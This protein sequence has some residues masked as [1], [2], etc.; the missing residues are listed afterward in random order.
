MARAI[1][2]K[3]EV[4]QGRNFSFIGESM[5]DT[6][7]WI[8]TYGMNT[9]HR[10]LPATLRDMANGDT[11]HVAR[12]DKLLEQVNAI[13]LTADCT[14]YVERVVAGGLAD[15]PAF[16][17]GS[18]VAMRQRRKREAAKPLTMV[19]DISTSGSVSDAGIQRRGVAILA[20]IQK[21]TQAGH[22]IT[23]H[24]AEASGIAGGAFPYNGFFITRLDTAPLDLARLCWGL[25]SPD[26]ARRIAFSAEL[27]LVPGNDGSGIGWPRLKG[28]SGIGGGWTD[29]GAQNNFPAQRQVW[30][31]I[32]GEPANSIMVVPP[33]FGGNPDHYP[34]LRDDKGAAEWVTE[35][36]AKAV[37][38][39]QE[40]N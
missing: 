9:P 30:A 36:Y 17:S 24:I 19:V 8:K 10:V 3:S 28:G 2:F 27:R 6:A 32:L 5:A 26:L 4:L 33:V 29:I 13:T 21:L 37:A 38:L 11:S 34:Y 40:L 7:E 23:L 22:P 1:E 35:Q 16:L 14:P 39:A 20:L 31:D 12:A 18:P 25:C 15:V